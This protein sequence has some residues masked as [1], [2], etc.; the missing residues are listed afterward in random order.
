MNRTLFLALSLVSLTGCLNL[1]DARNGG[2]QRTC[3]YEQ[4]CGK[5]GSG[6]DYPNLDECLTDQRAKFNDTW[7]VERCDGKINGEAL[8]VCFKAIENAQCDNLLDLI[9]TASKCSS[10][11]VC[12]ASNSGC[13]CGQGQTCCNNACV[14]LSND[15]NNC[16]TCGTQCGGGSSCNAG[17]CR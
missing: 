5:I 14:N 10:A 1:N 9:S 15:R 16:G 13:N 12:T 4:R 3:Q 8:D 7:S 11:N 2:A 6:Q 17:A